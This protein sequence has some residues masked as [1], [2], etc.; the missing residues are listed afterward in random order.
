MDEIIGAAAGNCNRETYA[1]PFY[2]LNKLHN[3]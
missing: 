3:R 1:G 2:Y